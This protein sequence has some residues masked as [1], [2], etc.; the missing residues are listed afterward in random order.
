MTSEWEVS[1][2]LKTPVRSVVSLDIGTRPLAAAQISTKTTAAVLTRGGILFVGKLKFAPTSFQ[3]GA[4]RLCSIAAWTHTLG[5]RNSRGAAM[6][7]AD[8][9]GGI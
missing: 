8:C 7:C 2:T 4:Q 3:I 1:A 5:N 6:R 9:T